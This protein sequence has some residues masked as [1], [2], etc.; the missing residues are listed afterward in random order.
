MAT[1][2]AAFAGMTSREMCEL[3]DV[4][5]S[6]CLLCTCTLVHLLVFPVEFMDG[7]RLLLKQELLEPEDEFSTTST[8]QFLK[9]PPTVLKAW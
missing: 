8:S 5:V 3:V 1:S 9:M 2:A 6:V 7:E 4:C